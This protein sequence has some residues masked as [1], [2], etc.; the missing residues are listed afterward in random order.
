VDL[1]SSSGVEL[2]AG[3]DATLAVSVDTASWF[4][5]DLLDTAT[6]S[7]SQIVVDLNNNTAVGAELLA[8]AVASFALHDSPIP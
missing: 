4:A 3:H 7:S 6:Q 5:G 1:R 8:R 2:S